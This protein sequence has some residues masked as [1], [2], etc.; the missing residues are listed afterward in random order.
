MKDNKFY[1]GGGGGILING[2]GPIASNAIGN[3][4]FG[5]PGHGYGPGSGCRGTR[6][7]FHVQCA[8]AC[9]R[10]LFV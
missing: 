10:F 9:I 5:M 7:T 8:C 1:G 2:V 4:D 3:N 6:N